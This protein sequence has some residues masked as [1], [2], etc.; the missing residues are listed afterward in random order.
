MPLT[1]NTVIVFGMTCSAGI[2]GMFQQLEVTPSISVIVREQRSIAERASGKKG[3]WD[4]NTKHDHLGAG[5][6]E[7]VANVHDRG[8]LAQSHLADVP[9]HGTPHLSITATGVDASSSCP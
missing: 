2:L 1:S 4:V 3:L 6:G 7:L 9:W 8:V 5:L